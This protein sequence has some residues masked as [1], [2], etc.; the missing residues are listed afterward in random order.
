MALH[1]KFQ[2]DTMTLSL[3]S[4]PQKQGTIQYAMFRC[5]Q[6]VQEP[7]MVRLYLLVNVALS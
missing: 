6:T 3:Y 1:S 5:K 2:Q 7:L 4:E